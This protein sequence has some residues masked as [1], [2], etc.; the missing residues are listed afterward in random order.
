LRD[1]SSVAGRNKRILQI[2]VQYDFLSMYISNSVAVMLEY[3]VSLKLV[4]TFVEYLN[5]EQAI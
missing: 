2:V 5:I 3:D 4:K 1:V